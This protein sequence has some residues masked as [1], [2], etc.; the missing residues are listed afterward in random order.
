MF[1]DLSIG[2]LKI[3]SFFFQRINLQTFKQQ[4]SFWN[5]SFTQTK[6]N[7]CFYFVNRYFIFLE[8]F[9]HASALDLAADSNYGIAVS[10]PELAVGVNEA[11]I[12]KL[13][14]KLDVRAFRMRKINER[15]NE[16]FLIHSQNPFPKV[17]AVCLNHPLFCLR[18]KYNN[19]SGS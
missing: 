19:Y 14:V 16:F 8:K 9:L 3:F 6:Y 5:R 11:I 2:S 10:G 13:M 15:A 17:V 12:P 1:F 7:K 4:T 18:S